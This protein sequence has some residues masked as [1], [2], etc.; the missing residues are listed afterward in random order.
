MKIFVSYARRDRP[1]V[2]VLLSDI[3]RAQHVVWFDEELTGGQAWWDTILSQI[4][5][6]DLFVMALSP[7][8]LKSR[9]CMAEYDYAVRCQ[10][11]VL[12]VKV[13]AVPPQLAPP[14]IANA[15]IIDY[16]ERTPNAAISLVTALN[17]TPPRP[18]LPDPLPVPP[19]VPISYMNTYYERLAEHSLTLQQQALLL[20]EL[21]VHLADED[22]RE[23]ALTLIRRLRGRGDITESV[24]RE[25]DT[26]LATLPPPDPT[27]RRGSGD[28]T[29]DSPDRTGH[30]DPP[31]TSDGTVGG[32]WKR[33]PFGRFE[34]RFW[35]GSAWTEHVSTQG[36]QSTDP[37]GDR[38][39]SPRSPQ[40]DA[41]QPSQPSAHDPDGPFGSGAY[42]ALI[43]AT[44]VIPLI[45][46]V[47]G[48][49]NLKKPRR[50]S[51]A[52]VLLAVGIGTVV[53]LMLATL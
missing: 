7:D 52:K 29:S 32:A 33:D 36:R 39:T 2:D 51:Q 24:G 4:R 1:A 21:R 38:T 8:S 40:L 20:S 19:P 45:G 15:Q 17:A 30:P 5:D 48:A 25:I 44:V 18:P 42:V 27:D 37:P 9:A 3:R 23:T 28:G 14:A 53:L 35:N 43:V 34:L 13:S 41:S 12:P 16:I 6:A 49:I 22:D 46:I 31:R 11:T 47:V 26:L 10:R 50:A